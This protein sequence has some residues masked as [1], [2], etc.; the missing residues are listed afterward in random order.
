[1]EVYNFDYEL[2]GVH[3]KQYA[4]SSDEILNVYL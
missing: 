1:L 3:S 4:L 2:T